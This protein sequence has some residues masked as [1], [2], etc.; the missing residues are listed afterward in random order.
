VR[1]TQAH[2]WIYT[3]WQNAE[4]VDVQ[5]DGA[6]PLD[7][8]LDPRTSIRSPLYTVWSHGLL[9]IRSPVH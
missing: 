5:A 1:I 3:V 6:L 2:K 8:T 9:L 7:F 4:A